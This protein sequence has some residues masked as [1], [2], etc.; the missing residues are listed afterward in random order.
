MGLNVDHLLSEK[1]LGIFKPKNSIEMDDKILKENRE[2]QFVTA[3]ENGKAQNIAVLN[4]SSLTSITDFMIIATGTS[5][6]HEVV[7]KQLI[8]D[9]SQFGVPIGVE[10]LQSGEWVLVDFGEIVIH[11]MLKTAREFYNLESLWNAG[12]LNSSD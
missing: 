12:F 5:S 3:L 2:F 4:V 6:R 1:L 9:K 10:G 11:I 8:E 7:G